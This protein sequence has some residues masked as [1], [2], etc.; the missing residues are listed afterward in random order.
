MQNPK[1]LKQRLCRAVN[2]KRQASSDFDLNPALELPK[3]RAL[4][5]AAVLVAV[6][7]DARVILTKRSTKLR[8]HPG[9]IAF[10]GGRQDETDRDLVHTALREA[11]EEIGLDSIYCDTNCSNGAQ[12]PYV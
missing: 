5:Q 10:P 11:E 9:Q 12:R 8:N 6:T 4:K 2:V 1:D 7:E 3:D